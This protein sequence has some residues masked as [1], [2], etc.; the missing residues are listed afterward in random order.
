MLARKRIP[1]L[2]AFLIL[3]GA[4]LTAAL[5]QSSPPPTTTAPPAS[6]RPESPTTPPAAKPSDPMTKPAAPAT[7]PDKSATAPAKVNP[8]IGLA[9]FSSDGTKLGAVQGVSAEPDGKVKAIHIRTGGFL[10]FGGKIVAIPEGKFTRA[11][12]NVRLSL[13]SDEVSKLPEV[14]G[15]S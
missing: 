10:G 13:T 3:A 7:S 4:P 15:Q 2:G 6:S 5:A 14:K 1:L 8:L 11:G 12:D 9:V